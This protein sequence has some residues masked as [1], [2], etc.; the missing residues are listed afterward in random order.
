MNYMQ[1]KTPEEKK[2][3]IEKKEATRKKNVLL[4]KQIEE[5]YERKAIEMRYGIERLEKKLSELKKV[6]LFQTASAKI[7]NKILLT[8]DEIVKFSRSWSEEVGVY[9][10]I[11]N[12]EV[13]YVGQ[14]VNIF[15]RISQHK[16][17]KK[18]DKYA[19]VPCSKESLDKLESLYI[20]FLRP[21]L[22]G[23][24]KDNVIS[25]PLTLEKLLD[26]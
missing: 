3:I 9:F 17:D 20:H 18:F 5:E 10:L 15:S 24:H 1:L 26:L 23:R 7:I 6:D 14:S 8:G 12:N 21:R 25:A 16:I 2:A 22:N 11:D 4:K 13:V 19:F